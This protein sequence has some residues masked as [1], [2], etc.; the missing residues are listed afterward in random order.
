MPVYDAEEERLNERSF[1]KIVLDCEVLSD[2][3]ADA[4]FRLIL[5]LTVK[6]LDSDA[7]LVTEP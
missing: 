4:V 2:H 1:V 6:T 7:D 5:K 3:V